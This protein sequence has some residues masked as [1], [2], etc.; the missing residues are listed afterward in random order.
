[1]SNTEKLD[2]VHVALVSRTFYNVPL[3]SSLRNGYFTEERLEVSEEILDSTS[4]VNS[5]LLA[6]AFDIGIG[7]PEG[8]IEDN[9][10]GSGELLIVGGNARKLTHFLVAQPEIKSFTD[11][12]GAVIGVASQN[13]GTAFVIKDILKTEGLAES[14]Y[15]LVD[16]GGAPSRWV[17]LQERRI[18][19]GLQSIPINFM[20]SDAGFTVLCD[21]AEYVPDYQF[22]TIN[23]TRSWSARNPK[24]LKRFLNALKRGTEWMYS[25]KD[26]A[27]KLI[28]EELGVSSAHAVRAWEYYTSN[29][30]IPKDLQLSTRALETVLR[31]ME[32]AGSIA[33]SDPGVLARCV[34]ISFLSEDQSGNAT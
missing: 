14:D 22:T 27:V 13:E 15:S 1:M 19:A 31:L 3:W 11:L 18:D 7:T 25:E 33:S 29:H 32:A 23:T 5:E 4:R 24:I 26:E 16:A 9:V 30:I 8:V 20:A 12:R 34:D 17:A 21:S 28:S 6:G 10:S 2:R